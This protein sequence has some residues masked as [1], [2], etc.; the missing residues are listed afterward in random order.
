VVLEMQR[1]LREATGRPGVRVA[2]A[3]VVERFAIPPP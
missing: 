2:L 3:E 1:H